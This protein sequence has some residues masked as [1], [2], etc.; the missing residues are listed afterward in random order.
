MNEAM[1]ERFECLRIIDAWLEVIAVEG[2]LNPEIC[3]N[4]VQHIRNSIASR[5]VNDTSNIQ[6]H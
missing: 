2:A 1:R 5:C 3:I 6:K 4:A